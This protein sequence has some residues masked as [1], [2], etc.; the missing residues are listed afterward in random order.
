MKIK[1][2]FCEFWFEDKCELAMHFYPKH[3]YDISYALADLLFKIH[4]KI[5]E[6]ENGIP[7][8]QGYALPILKYLLE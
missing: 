2:P 1:C 8:E 5:E 7:L 4:E 3:K 6:F